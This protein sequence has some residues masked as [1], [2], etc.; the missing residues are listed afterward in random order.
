MS[1]SEV[2]VSVI[3]PFYN[4]YNLVHQV[5]FDLYSFC[6][7]SIDEIIL[8]NDGSGD[9][10]VYDGIDWWKS[11]KMLPIKVL[12]MEENV[13]FLR[14][15]NAGLR[16]AKGSLKVLISNDVLI[17]EDIITKIL[18]MTDKNGPLTLVGCRYYQG[19][20]GWNEFN[21]KIFPYLEGWLLASTR[22]GWEELGGGFD[23]RFSPNDYEDVDLSTTAISK[24]F[25]LFELQDAKVTHIGAQ[26]I[27]YSSSRQALTER[28]REKFKEKWNC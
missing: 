18:D 5:L 6:R 7:E 15:S 25:V 21:G 19:S 9:R 2:K 23:E 28:N 8:V 11:A 14:A 4:H 13:G 20:T 12:D 22:E 16:K 10:E 1:T 3:I 27:G 26:S 17:K 24:D